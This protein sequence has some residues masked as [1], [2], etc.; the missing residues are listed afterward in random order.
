MTGTNKYLLNQQMNQGRQ[1]FLLYG[2]IIHVKVSEGFTISTELK[3][4]N[5]SL[6][7]INFNLL[8][9]LKLFNTLLQLCTAPLT[10]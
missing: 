3:K 8:L 2:K 5:A 7:H 6:T 4:E 1:Y 9:F 10:G